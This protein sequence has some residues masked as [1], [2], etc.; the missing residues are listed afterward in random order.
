MGACNSKTSNQIPKVAR[1]ELLDDTQPLEFDI[2]ISNIQGRNFKK[3]DTF[4][5][6]QFEKNAELQTHYVYESANP[7]V[8]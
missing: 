1:H 2:E 5:K 6:I 3:K 7:V 8:K 4:L